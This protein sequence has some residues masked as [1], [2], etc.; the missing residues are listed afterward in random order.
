MKRLLA[1]SL[2][3]VC[4]LGPLGG[5]AAWGQASKDKSATSGAKAAARDA[6][7]RKTEP[8][9]INSASAEEL[10][11]VKGIGASTAK[12]IIA[13]RPYKSKDELVAKKAMSQASYEKIKDQLVARQSAAAAP[14]A[15]PEKAA[16]TETKKAAPSASAP[17]AAPRTT[18]SPKASAA[19]PRT[20]ESPK[21]SAEPA[22]KPPAP[23]MVWVNTESKVF[24]HEG[25]RWYG[26][27]KAGKYMTE[28]EALREGYRAAKQ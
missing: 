25:D 19:A 15:P 2:V 14:P 1:W 4:A 24:H 3:L 18:E 22:Q 13:G 8:V 27:T 11:A 21:A 28:A 17:A 10:E 6:D 20:T 26:K 9:D 16:R 7:A 5:S 23:G 12:K